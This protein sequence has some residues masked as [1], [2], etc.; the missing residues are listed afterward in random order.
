VSTPPA[1]LF[2]R[3][4]DSLPLP[5]HELTSAGVE[6]GQ[7]A[8]RELLGLGADA[9]PAL[10][11]ALASGDFPVKDAAY[12]LIIEMGEPVRE[13]LFREL[14]RRGPVVDIWIAGALMNL[15][16]DGAFDRLRPLLDDPDGY[17]R[18]LAALAMAFHGDSTADLAAVLLEA[19]DD[20]D[21]IEGTAF[22]VA[23]SAL[24]MLSRLAGRT[25][26]PDGA[27]IH[28]YNYDHFVYPPPTHPFPFAADMLTHAD[29]ETRRAIV[30]DARRWWSDF[31]S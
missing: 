11:D 31:R 3:F 21:T 1:D 20:D 25:L 7:Q 23:G 15:G 30:A 22:T 8:R 2:A 16:D 5:G 24:A 26:A 13:A 4:V 10:L 18:H 29:P 27:D 14:G 19:L 17:T 6:S 9:V 12:D 28:L